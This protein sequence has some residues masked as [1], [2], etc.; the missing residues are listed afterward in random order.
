MGE[1]SSNWY[2]CV[3]WKLRNFKIRHILLS[4]TLWIIKLVFA[5]KKNR[6]SMKYQLRLIFIWICL[7]TLDTF[8]SASDRWE[9]RM[10]EESRPGLSLKVPITRLHGVF[11]ENHWENLSQYGRLLGSLRGPFHLK[12]NP[13][14]TELWLLGISPSWVL[15]LVIGRK[16]TFSCYNII[17]NLCISKR[18]A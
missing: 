15:T 9:E 16:L 1:V 11:K 4:I 6:T 12:F 13:W 8:G 5:F 18:F 2:I 7:Y 14:P 3:S 17:F 10:L